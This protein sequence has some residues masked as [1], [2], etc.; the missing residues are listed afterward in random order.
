MLELIV[1]G[2]TVVDGTG[3][4]RIVADVGIREGKIE[5]IGDLSQA[6]AVRWIDARGLV[7]AP[8][9]V[10]IH[11]HS[12]YTLLLDPRGQS[13][14]AQGVTTE[15]VGNC[16]HGCAPIADPAAASGNIYGYDPALPITWHALA[17]YFAELEKARP[18]VNVATLVPNGMLRIAVS[19]LADRPAT[20]AELRQMKRLLEQ[21]MEEGA[22]GFSSGLEYPVERACRAEELI[23]LCQIAA[24][25]GGI[26]ATHV[27][28]R[29]RHPIEA[30]DEAIDTA[31]AAGIRLHIPHLAPR[32]GGPPDPEL[33]ALERIDRALA[34]GTD[35]SVDM[36]TRLHGLTNL[37][38]ALPAGAFA[39]GPEALRARLRD[40]MLREA[41]RQH[42]SLITSFALGGWETVSLLFSPRRADLVG[43]T[44]PAIAEELGTDPFGA[45]LDV[46]YDEA[47]DPHAPLVLCASYTEDQLRRNFV[48]PACGV[49]SD[50]TAL[51]VDGPLAHKVFHGAFTWAAW[52]FRRWV[53]EERA[54][55][56]EEGIRKLT[57]WPAGRL[58]LAN[59]GVLRPEA[60]ADVAIFDPATYGERGTL[61]Q[62]NQLAVGMRYV[63]VNG[64]VEL[65][66]GA[67]TGA[68]GGQVLRR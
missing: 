65:A 66:D 52:F 49:A 46:L 21:G 47:D 20:P 26:Y 57:G 16:G 11:S 67:F 41:F 17:D 2:G 9:F 7:V 45:I 50:A 29:D 5:A 37:S 15:L 12:D 56:L 34:E 61:R 55:T 13:S 53:R 64:V 6:E 54:F 60:H 38:V 39:G 10:D 43:K 36:H 32:K 1:A 18:A 27:R 68:R 59:R 58:G 22:F 35:V 28:N 44:F 8:G 30:I 25:Y 19:G 62:P 31:R 24:R 33:R 51:G 14:V 3:R 40:P 4:P 42:E 63:L 48:H 23:E